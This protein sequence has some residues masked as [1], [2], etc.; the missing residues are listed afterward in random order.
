MKVLTSPRLRLRRL[1]IKDAYFI[2]E[3]LNDPDWLRYIG[4]RDVNSVQDAF[5]Y[6]QQGPQGMYL[7]Y[8]T[9]LLLVES[10]AHGQPLGLCGL[11]KRME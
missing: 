1:T 10:L 6:I 8:A 2:V 4:D 3:L 7:Q 11:L 9:G 5:V